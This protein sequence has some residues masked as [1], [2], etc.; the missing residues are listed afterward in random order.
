MTFGPKLCTKLV[1][2]Q[3]VIFARKS[4]FILAGSASFFAFY[5]LAV[6][7]P[8]LKHSGISFRKIACALSLATSKQITLIQV[9]KQVRTVPVNKC[10]DR[11]I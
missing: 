8:D 5:N 7:K 6:S 9:A 2:P 11:L 3:N 1:L 10:G 4:I